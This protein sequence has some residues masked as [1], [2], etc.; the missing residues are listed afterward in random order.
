LC[1]LGLH[2]SIAS[3]DTYQLATGGV[4]DNT[5]GL[6]KITPAQYTALKPLDFEVGGNTYSLTPNAQIW[7]RSLNSAIGGDA[8]GIYLIVADLGEASTEYAF[9]NG[10]A[11]LSVINS[12]I[13]RY[14][15]NVMFESFESS[16]R[17]Y[18]VYDTGNKRVGFAPTQVS[19]SLCIVFFSHL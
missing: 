16:Q 19:L 11:F 12:C 4:P 13:P 3:F 15:T 6:L 9:V 1:S 14:S 7:P 18:S 10:Y 5:T 2:F 17:F 8:G